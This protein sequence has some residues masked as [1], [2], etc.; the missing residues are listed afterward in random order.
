MEFAIQLE[1][2][3]VKIVTLLER[4][5]TEEATKNALIMPFIQ[6]L[7]YDVF[8]PIEVVPEFIADIGMKKGE[9][10]DYAIMDNDTPIAIIECK[11]CTADLTKVHA[12]QLHR[13]FHTTKARI[14]ILTNGL[15]YMFYSDLDS[16]NVMDK[17]PF[18]TI[19]MLDIDEQLIPELKKLTKS[20]FELDNMLSTA[21]NLKHTREIKSQLEEQLNS[22]S[23]E[24]VKLL[25][26]NIYA[27]PKTHQVVEH[28]T[29]LIKKSFKG[30]ITDHI[31]SR[32]KSAFSEHQE[33]EIVEEASTAP[34]KDNGVV[35]TEEELE[36]FM[37]IKAI[38]REVVDIKR[39]QHRDT[40]SY[41]GVL[42]DDNNRKPIC[43]LH[44]NTTQKY[45]G[46]IDADK[47]ETRQPIDTL[48]DIYKWA[49]SIKDTVGFYE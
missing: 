6:T 30:L 47:N 25:L 20:S 12:S 38:L 4:V 2:L 34:E 48:D 1:A 41:F 3:S 13:Y 7:G 49:S 31:N 28:F 11:S 8:N 35:T 40:K 24:F 42:L 33:E 32:L 46:I 9:K 21:N 43:R 23:P 22:P 45:I 10:V 29:P 26:S 17:T 39:L 19:N 14:G 18:M 15:E 16:N 37:I 44:F 27:G 36:G 5:Q